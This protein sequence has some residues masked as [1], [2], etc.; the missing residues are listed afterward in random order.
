MAFADFADNAST[1]LPKLSKL[2]FADP[3]G[4]EAVTLTNELARLAQDVNVEVA[5]LKNGID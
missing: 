5:P 2:R 3:F 1:Q 4:F